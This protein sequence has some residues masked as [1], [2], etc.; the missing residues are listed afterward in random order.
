MQFNKN[1]EET[2]FS[3]VKQ[4]GEEIFHSTVSPNFCQHVNKTKENKI[5]GRK[6]Q[7]SGARQGHS[8]KDSKSHLFILDQAELFNMRW[9]LVTTQSKLSPRVFSTMIEMWRRLGNKVSSRAIIRQN[10][11][12]LGCHY[13]F[14]SLPVAVFRLWKRGVNKQE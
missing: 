3:Y 2:V 11:R 10:I 7:W 8:S 12:K 14:R 6:S 4:V 1:T 5:E 13:D 9:G